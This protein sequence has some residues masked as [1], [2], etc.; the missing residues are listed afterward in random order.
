MPMDQMPPEVQS[1]PVTVQEAYQFTAANPDVMKN[2]PCY[3]GCG[4]IGHTSN[5]DC[6]VSD[7]DARSNIEFDNHALGC[8]I[9][10]DITQDVMR[11]LQEGK[12]PQEA[13]LYIDTT[14]SKYGPS[15]I[16]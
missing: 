7:V 10:V 12:S 9:C 6:Y 3:C 4:D 2:I 8:S 11:M 15:N 13:R 16:P 14:Y 5:Y 1:A